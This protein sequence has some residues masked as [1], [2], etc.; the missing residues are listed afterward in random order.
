MLKRVALMGAIAALT[1]GN[2]SHS[3]AQDWRGGWGPGGVTVTVGFPG[4]IF[5]RP[6]SCCFGP[7][8]IACCWDRPFPPG[9]FFRPPYFYGDRFAPYAYN[10][11]AYDTR[12]AGY[13]GW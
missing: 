3:I 9:P 8:P 7:R 2:P 1:I 12:F 6:V 4:P 13:G 11:Y 10:P 5:R